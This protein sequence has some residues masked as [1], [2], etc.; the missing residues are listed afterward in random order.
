M[1]H[2]GASFAPKG[3]GD[4][5]CVW[6]S[7]NGLERHLSRLAQQHVLPQPGQLTLLVV[8][9][10]DELPLSVR[11]LIA[12]RNV[13]AL[14]AVNCRQACEP[15]L[16]ARA[17]A[18]VICGGDDYF[19]PPR[20]GEERASGESR[21]Q[22]QLLADA[23]ASHRLT[24]VVLSPG[25]IGV[26][27]GDDDPLMQAPADISADELWGRIAAIQQYRPLLRRMEEQVSGMQRLGKKLNEQFVEVDQE[28]RLASRLQRDFLPKQLP[29][30]GDIR[31]HVIYRPAT[32]V[33]GD[34]YDVQ[35]LDESVI[36][37]YLADAVG[38]GVAAGLL[39][40]FI[41]QAIV[42]KR[43]VQ[44]GYFIVPPE[45]VLNRLNS[46]L[47]DQQ[48]PNCQFVTACYATVD[49]RTCEICLA[50]GGHPHPIHV[51]IDG[52]CV[53]VRTV[54]GLLGIFHEE[55]FP[56]TSLVLEPGE[57]LVLYSDGLEDMIIG[58][59]ERDEDQIYFTPTFL[60]AVRR[61]G[62][63]CIRAIEEQLDAAEGSLQ[64]SD[65]MTVLLVERLPE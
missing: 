13:A 20:A 58:R 39:T 10:P 60:E 16:L 8:G 22:L 53:E 50:R 47:A 38:H 65:D 19:E 41:K 24:G 59:R 43:I 1:R 21:H 32:W 62:A 30:V 9:K 18:V 25:T 35:R 49:L 54:G 2:I 7:L 15:S 4:S 31:F 51:G 61:P 64:P 40:M 33:C 27:P 42:G 5:A 55:T 46:Q 12:G 48:L 45:D 17:D 36:G 34:V 14:H 52:T 3:D 57:K 44:D 11:E 37:F 29:S 56:S 6:T 23:L 26:V 28:L 63:Q